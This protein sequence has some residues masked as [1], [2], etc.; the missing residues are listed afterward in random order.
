[1]AG[2]PYLSKL[3]RALKDL[4]GAVS[5]EVSQS[6]RSIRLRGTLPTPEGKWSRQ[7]ISTP[8]PY[9]AG[10]QQAR[11]RAEQLGRDLQLHRMGIETFPFQQWKAGEVATNAQDSAVSGM[12]AIRL[13]ERWWQ[14]QRKRGPSAPTTWAKDYAEP[15]APLRDL[16]VVTLE[17]LKAL[18]SSREPGSRTRRR[19]FQEA[20]NRPVLLRIR[21]CPPET[22]TPPHHS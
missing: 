11:Q 6:G 19:A 8:W 15:L 1:V 9:P 17:S 7:R 5:L 2:D 14:S 20:G 3:N 22:P 10:L 13:T 16:R 18:V 4:G 21:S 12:E